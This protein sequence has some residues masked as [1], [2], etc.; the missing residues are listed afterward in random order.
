MMPKSNAK[1]PQKTAIM[2]KSVSENVL[3]KDKSQNKE[4][5][6]EIKPAINPNLKELPTDLFSKTSNRGISAKKTSGE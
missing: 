4:I 5:T 2:Q 1:I 6:Y 3:N